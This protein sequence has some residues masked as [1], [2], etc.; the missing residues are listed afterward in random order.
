MFVILFIFLFLASFISPIALCLYSS[1]PTLAV[2]LMLGNLREKVKVEKYEG[3]S[4]SKLQMDIV[5]KQT[6]VLT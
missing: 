2:S 5:L 6:R 3:K 1:M 4:I